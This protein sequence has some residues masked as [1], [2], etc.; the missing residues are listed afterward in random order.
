MEAQFASLP[1]WLD[2]VD[3]SDFSK[4]L[5]P[6]DAAFV[7]VGGG[8]GQQCDALLKKFPDLRGRVVLQ[9]T[10]NVLGKALQVERMEKMSYDYLTE[11]PVKGTCTHLFEDTS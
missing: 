1:T 10:P 4:G 2:V 7:D 6:S 5:T 8:N 3:F 11:Q 9:D